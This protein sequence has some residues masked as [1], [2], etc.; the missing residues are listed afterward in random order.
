[1]TYNFCQPPSYRMTSIT[2]GPWAPPLFDDFL[3]YDPN[4][5]FDNCRGTSGR[6]LAHA[7]PAVLPDDAIRGQP[8]TLR[9]FGPTGSIVSVYASFVVPTPPIPLPIGDLWLDPG[10]ILHVGTGAVDAN[11][12]LTLRTTIPS[13]LSIGDV[14]VYQALSL[15]PSSQWELSEPGFAVVQ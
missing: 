7:F 4:V 8:Q 15:T 3:V 6:E 10:L 5:T 11:R 14:L 9:C 1:M 12:R 2:L 13:W